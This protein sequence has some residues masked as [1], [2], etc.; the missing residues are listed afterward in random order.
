MPFL[1]VR[2]FHGEAD[3][4]G[5]LHGDGTAVDGAGG[6]FLGEGGLDGANGLGVEGC[7]AGGFAYYEIGHIASGC[8]GESHY[9]KPVGSFGNLAFG[10]ADLIENGLHHG[11]LAGGIFWQDLAFGGRLLTRRFGYGRGE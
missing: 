10:E 11:L 7:V 9:H 3:G 8:D 4:E 1:C 2:L 6:P 5:V